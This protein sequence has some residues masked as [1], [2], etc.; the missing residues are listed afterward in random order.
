MAARQ[1]VKELVVAVGDALSPAPASARPWRRL[2]SGH[3]IWPPQPV[4]SGSPSACAVQA[5][6]SSPPI[7]RARAGLPHRV[8]STRHVRDGVAGLAATWVSAVVI[9][10][11]LAPLGL[12]R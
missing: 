11:A 2:A 9:D 4:G 3:A 6:T 8:A 10:A 1:R 5:L 7:R 12:L